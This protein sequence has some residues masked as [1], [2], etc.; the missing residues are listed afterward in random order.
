MSCPVKPVRLQI[1]SGTDT[2]WA[3]GATGPSCIVLAKGELGYDTVNHV[4]K[5]GDGV[6]CWVNL[7]SISGGGGGGSTSSTS[8]YTGGGG[9]GGGER[10]RLLAAVAVDG[11]RFDAQLAA[12]ALNPQGDFAP[13]G[14]QDFLEHGGSLF[15]Q[16]RT[17]AVHI[18]PPGRFRP[19][20]G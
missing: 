7:P 12:G 8:K 3:T 18:P 16:S 2:Q 4:L 13:V 11:H 20:S 17:G 14:D 1:R 10:L 19:G 9:A 6:S 15:I 5:V